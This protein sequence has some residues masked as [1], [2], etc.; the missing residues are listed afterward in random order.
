MLLNL[1]RLISLEVFKF[2]INFIFRDF[3][4]ER[5][6]FPQRL[7]LARP[8]SPSGRL[9]LQQVFGRKRKRRKLQVDRS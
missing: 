4:R 8:R 2:S 5:V 1:G 3:R 6:R 7:G 9:A